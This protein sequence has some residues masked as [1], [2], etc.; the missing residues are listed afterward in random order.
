MF[1]GFI[2]DE[3]TLI[4]ERLLLTLG[5][6][7]D[8]NDFTGLEVQPNARLMW[9]PNNENS[10][11]LAVSRAVRTP[12]RAEN[13][14]HLNAMQLQNLPGIPV[15]PL[16]ILAVFQ[17]SHSYNSEKLIAYE[18]GYR[19]QFS[20]RASVDV[21][22]FV[23]DYSQL[24]D[25]SFGALSLSTGLPNQLILST[26][27]NNHASALTYGF[28]LSTD[29]RPI[30]RWRLQGNYSF[31]DM[32]ISSNPLTKPLDSAVSGADK[33]NLQHQV[34]VRSNFDLS[35]KLEINLW[36]R[37][38]SQIA[39]YHIPGFVTMDAKLTYKPA[40]NVELFLVG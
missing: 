8:R 25:F 5:T 29:W 21:A 9:M 39:F 4:P 12:S 23:N 16:P 26:I 24:R 2:R 33:A 1:S 36:L 14:V 32:Q 3:I 7:L 40:K 13:D 17:G 10:A 18:L 34:S 31:L 15:S 22:G 37:Y 27:G 20:S 28:E 11:W 30:D 35:D 38:S 6:R 19:H